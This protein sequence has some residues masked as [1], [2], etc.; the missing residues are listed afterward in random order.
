MVRSLYFVQTQKVGN[1]DHAKGDRNCAL[2]VCPATRGHGAEHNSMKKD[3]SAARE[4]TQVSLATGEDVKEPG[5]R[6]VET[7]DF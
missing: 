1:K 2:S 6:A 4:D 3:S 5:G 7:S